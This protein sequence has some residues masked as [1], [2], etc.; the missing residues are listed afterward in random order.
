MSP[1]NTFRVTRSKW[2]HN[3]TFLESLLNF[4]FSIP[5][6]SAHSF[7]FYFVDLRKLWPHQKLYPVRFPEVALPT[8]YFCFVLGHDSG[9]LPLLCRRN[10]LRCLRSCVLLGISNYHSEE[11]SPILHTPCT[12]DQRMLQRNL[13]YFHLSSI[14]SSLWCSSV[15]RISSPDTFSF[16]FFQLMPFFFT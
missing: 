5:R 12:L 6:S 14:F 10:K 13:S 8:A 1:R 15:V 11:T 2:A 3:H 4:F 7:S 16:H 9:V